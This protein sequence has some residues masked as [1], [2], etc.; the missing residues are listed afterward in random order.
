MKILQRL[1]Q[2]NNNHH[3]FNKE[4]CAVSRTHWHAA[5]SK[6][7]QRR[8]FNSSAFGTALNHWGLAKHISRCRCF[9]SVCVVQ[10]HILWSMRV[11]AQLVCDKC[12]WI[13]FSPLALVT[14]DIENMDPLKIFRTS[15][16]RKFKCD[17]I[18]VVLPYSYL[19]TG[20]SIQFRQQLDAIL[21]PDQN[22]LQCL[23]VL[24]HLCEVQHHWVTWYM[25]GVWMSLF[26]WFTCTWSSVKSPSRMR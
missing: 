15:R 7:F 20:D 10:T 3:H 8:V 9:A 26:A 4:A 14:F 11:D 17:F 16:I 13:P 22:A 19:I 18:N 12:V 21:P 23:A 5:P 24:L 6:K 2:L 25:C 1:Q